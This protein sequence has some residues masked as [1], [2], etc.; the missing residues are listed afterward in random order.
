MNKQ[1]CAVDAAIQLSLDEKLRLEEHFELISVDFANFDAMC[2]FE[3]DLM[4]IH[5]KVSNEV[6]QQLHKCRYI[7]IR[8]HN[9]DYIDSSMAKKLGMTVSGIPQ[10]GANAVAEHTFSLIFALTK[11]IL[12]SNQNV[13]SGNWRD[14]LTPNV[15]LFG[16]KIGIIGYGAIGQIVAN[17]GRALGMT[18]LIASRGNQIE[19]DRLPLEEVLGQSDIVTLHASSK[20]GNEHLINQERIASMRDGAILINTARGKLIDYVAL[21]AAL[22]SGKLFGAG[23]DVFPDEP[24]RN[25]SICHLRNVVCTPH[26]AFYTDRTISIMNDHLIN[27]AIQYMLE[28]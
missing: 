19:E 20:A 17:I 24:I 3:F 2:N 15:E 6:L 9:T 14:G 16:K 11:Q 28:N 21:E 27:N 10:V 7:G 5:S 8:A 18:I 26:V 25:E 22:K 12:P 23:L 4:L 13:V 1:S